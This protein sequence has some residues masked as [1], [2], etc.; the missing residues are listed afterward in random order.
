[1][2]YQAKKRR[3]LRKVNSQG[4]RRTVKVKTKVIYVDDGSLVQKEWVDL[5]RVEA[6]AL[7]IGDISLE[8]WGEKAPDALAK[9]T[10]HQ[11]NEL[12]TEGLSPPEEYLWLYPYRVDEIDSKTWDRLRMLLIGSPKVGLYYEKEPALGN[13]YQPTRHLD[14]RASVLECQVTQSKAIEQLWLPRNEEILVEVLDVGLH[15]TFGS[16]LVHGALVEH[17]IFSQMEQV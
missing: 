6:E 1:M 4:I 3:K 9:L 10:H 13:R 5:Q 7:R 2:D 12:A 14:A 16:Y 8:T 15:L 17:E 11:G